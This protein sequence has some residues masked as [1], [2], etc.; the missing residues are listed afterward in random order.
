[1][2]SSS[3]TPQTAEI[4]VVDHGIDGAEALDG[5]GIV[6][7]GIDPEGQDLLEERRVRAATAGVVAVPIVVASPRWVS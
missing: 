3:P 4:R 5:G 6:S 2:P 1:L 7:R